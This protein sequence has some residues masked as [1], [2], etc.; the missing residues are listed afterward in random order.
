MPASPRPRRARSASAG[1]S[2]APRRGAPAPAPRAPPP[3]PGPT[4][5]RELPWGESGG[6]GRGAGARAAGV[7]DGR[8]GAARA[9]AVQP[10]VRPPGL[11]AHPLRQ[12]RLQEVPLV[13]LQRRHRWVTGLPARAVPPH[14]VPFQVAPESSWG[15]GEWFSEACFR[16]F[17]PAQGTWS[18]WTTTWRLSCRRTITGCTPS[19]FSILPG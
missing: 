2:H 12:P 1:A 8:V 3:P 10:Q 4:A 11:G 14:G 13:A 9:P 16:L 19:T 5:P 6:G 18:R 17:V 15:L 7:R